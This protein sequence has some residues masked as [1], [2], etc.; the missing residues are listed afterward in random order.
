MSVKIESERFEHGR[1]LH[2]PIVRNSSVGRAVI[3]AVKFEL[4]YG[5]RIDMS[6]DHMTTRSFKIRTPTFA[7]LDITSFTAESDDEYKKLLSAVHAYLIV[8]N[9][10]NDD[11]MLKKLFP[12]IDTHGVRAFDITHAYP[13]LAGA[14][15][16]RTTFIGLLSKTEQHANILKGL[17]D[18]DM[19]AVVELCFDG[20]DIEDVITLLD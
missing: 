2:A 12:N 20:M 14:T 10:L 1:S 9:K 4:G 3:S 5:G 18:E 16:T 7:M 6:E 17:K 13:V 8:S 19:D 11:V 15:R